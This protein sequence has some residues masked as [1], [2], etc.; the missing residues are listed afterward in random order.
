MTQTDDAGDKAPRGWDCHAHLFG[1][2]ARYPLA[3]ERSYTP[4]EATLV[5][6]VAMLDQLGL[7]HCVLVQPSAYRADYR[8]VLDTLALRPYWRGV[9][10]SHDASTALM[11]SWRAAGIR[12]LRF[13]HRSGPAGNFPGSA[14]LADLQALAPRMA[15]AGLHAELW[16]DCAALPEIAPMLRAL[17]IPV[18]LDHM[19]GFDHRAGIGAPGFQLL[20]ELV[21]RHPVWVKLCAYRNLRDAPDPQVG[22]DFV[23]SLCQA[24][25]SQMV[26][27]S[28]WPHLNLRPAPVTHDLLEQFQA[29]ASDTALV[30]QILRENPARL[31]G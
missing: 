27:G 18:V 4:P 29:L 19:A 12:G 8:L 2:Y 24:N 31:Y 6:C 5:D 30:Q 3:A 20:L 10:V 1:P 25:A 11:R 17:P 16:T 22:Q 13:S 14:L 23:R 21:A 7:Q 26:W 9:L 15:E 28:D